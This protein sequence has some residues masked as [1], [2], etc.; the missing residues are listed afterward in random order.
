ME[1]QTYYPIAQHPDYLSGAPRFPDHRI[2]IGQL[3][4]HLLHGMTLSTF[5]SHYDVPE[6]NIH[7]LFDLLPKILPCG[8]NREDIRR[9]VITDEPLDSLYLS[10]DLSEKEMENVLKK[11][12]RWSPKYAFW[13]GDFD[14][15]YDEDD[16]ECRFL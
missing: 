15:I 11:S 13:W 6:E 14:V 3:G 1:Q 12:W 8:V 9:C 5:L 7:D 16:W 4:V 10:T 2:A